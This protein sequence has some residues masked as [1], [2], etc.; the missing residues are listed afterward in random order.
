MRTYTWYEYWHEA[1]LRAHDAEMTLLA[2]CREVGLA[3]LDE[4]EIEAVRALRAQASAA[5]DR[6]REHHAKR[7]Q[8]IIRSRD[9]IRR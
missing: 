3:P 1:S 9:A 8:E 7:H 6:F 5:W 2:K 4:S